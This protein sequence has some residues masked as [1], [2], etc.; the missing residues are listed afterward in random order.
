MTDPSQ[1]LFWVTSRAA[2]TAALVLSSASVGFGLTLGA[3]MFKRSGPDRRI[4]HE[5]LALSV[6]VAIAIHG[7]SLIGDKWLHPSLLDVTLPFAASY[8]TLATSVGIIAGWGLILL[9]LSYYLRRRIGQRRWRSIHRFT[10]LAWALGLVHAFTEGSDAGKLWFV[11][12]VA[13]TAAPAVAMLLVRLAPLV[14][15]GTRTPGSSG[16]RS[17]PPTTRRARRSLASRP[18]AP[19]TTSPPPRRRGSFRSPLPTPD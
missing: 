7:L 12:L 10:L 13:V 14:S 4:I 17:A 3:K 18:A 5:A 15:R 16:T 8:K 2:G 6:I 19:P 11:A 1:Q 9:G